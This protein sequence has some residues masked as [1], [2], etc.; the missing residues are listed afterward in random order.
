[1]NLASDSDRQIMNPVSFFSKYSLL[2]TFSA[3]IPQVRINYLCTL[4]QSKNSRVMSTTS[5]AVGLTVKTKIYA[6]IDQVWAIFNDPKHIV[7]WYSASEDWHTPE[8]VNNLVEGGGF[9]YRMEAKDESVGFHFEGS[10]ESIVDHEEINAVLRDGR[11][12]K[13]T[14]APTTKSR[15]LVVQ[16]FEAESQN[17]LEDQAKGW[18]AILDSFTKY[19]EGME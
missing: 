11:K 4:K 8:A 17:S 19:V 2:T 3:S 1:M 14:F 12:I 6:S 9:N 10:Y 5:P 15:T 18:Q 13:T 7:K 16:T